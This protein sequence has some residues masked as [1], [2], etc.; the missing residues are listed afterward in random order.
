MPSGS[1][2]LLPKGPLPKDPKANDP[3]H[4]LYGGFGRYVADPTLRF[5]GLRP[6]RCDTAADRLTDGSSRGTNHPPPH[7][8]DPRPESGRRRLATF[9]AVPTAEATGSG[10]HLR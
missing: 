9:G 6:S 7:P 10:R 3:L 2:G 5:I 1:F 4:L 8:N